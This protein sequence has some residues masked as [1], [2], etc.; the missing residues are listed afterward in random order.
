[1]LE[2]EQA[3]E[4]LLE[5]GIKTAA[6]LLD[7][8]LETA[9]KE[10]T[11][12]LTFLTGLLNCEK[13]ERKRR[14]EETRIKLSRLPHHKT[15]QEF[16]FSFQPSIDPRQIKELS[17]LAFAARKENVILLGPPGVG[18]THLSVALSIEALRGG[19]TV[20]YTTLPRLIA[21][22]KKVIMADKLERKL[23]T[24]L[25]PD[26]LVIDEVGYMQL[27]RQAAEIL[28]RIVSSRYETGSIILT[29]NKHFAGW[30]ELMSDPVIATAM[31][32]R[33]LHHA[34]VINIRGETYR[35]R[36]RAKA[37][38]VSVP[39]AVINPALS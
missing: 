29:S 18:K 21:D 19:M 3:R 5:M 13:E 22:M 2:L 7:A 34:H 25:R 24:F 31:L 30:G 9:V 17:T 28:F 10:E 16:D 12:Y 32:D 6:D 33:L 38:F 36:E 15:I 8:H 4:L 37:G 26:I 14:S 39:P 35:L 27:D 1:M 11:T 23:K 20:Y